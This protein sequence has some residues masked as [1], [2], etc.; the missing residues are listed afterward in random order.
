MMILCPPL[1]GNL[2]LALHAS[3]W[4]NRTEERE[5]FM[6]ILTATGLPA[7]AAAAAV[8]HLWR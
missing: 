1:S 2:L 7:T 8:Q 3:F 5:E 4:R 6:P